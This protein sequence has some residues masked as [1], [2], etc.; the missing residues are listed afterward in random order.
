MANINEI[1]ARAA[2]LRDETALNSISPERAGGIMYDTLLAL[3]ELWLQ[4]GAA[5][6]ISKIYASVA[7][8]EA[9]TAPVSDLTGK[10]LRPGQIV[11][12]ASSDS[13]NGSVYRYNGTESPS[14]SLVGSIGNLDP[15]DSLDSDS[16]T[17]PLAA[18]QG[19]V[20]DGKISQLGQ[21]VAENIMKYA[22]VIDKMRYDNTSASFIF[23]NTAFL[24]PLIKIPSGVTSINW[25][26]NGATNVK[27][28][29]LKED[30]TILDYY[31]QNPGSS[32]TI[33]LPA[34][35]AY[36]RAAFDWDVH[37]N[38]NK[39]SVTY[40]DNVVL[41]DEDS[42]FMEVA[43]IDSG[44]NPFSNK[45]TRSIDVYDK[46]YSLTGLIPNV[47]ISE[48]QS[49]LK[50]FYEYNSTAFLTELIPLNGA[51]TIHW[52]YHDVSGLRIGFYDENKKC[53]DSW[54]QSG[55]DREITVP[56]G[57]VF[58]RGAFDWN[59]HSSLKDWKIVDNN[60]NLLWSE[61]MLTSEMYEAIKDLQSNV[62]EEDKF[63]LKLFNTPSAQAP[64]NN[65][66]LN[67]E[68][69]LNTWTSGVFKIS[70]MIPV[71]IGD[72]V[73]FTGASTGTSAPLVGFS[74][75]AYGAENFV[76]DLIPEN[77]YTAN[78]E[79]KK[80]VKITNTAIKYVASCG[81]VNNGA[82]NF[83]VEVSSGTNVIEDII[84]LSSLR[85]YYPNAM[86]K[87]Q[88]FVQKYLSGEDVNIML[89]GDSIT[90]VAN[91]KQNSNLNE[92]P[93]FM[94]HQNWCYWL[95]K[96]INKS[97]N[98]IH[99]R[100]D[101]PDFFTFTGTFAETSANSLEPYNYVSTDENP[102]FEFDWNLADYEKTNVLL[103]RNGGQCSGGIKIEILSNGV[104]T[105]DLVEYFNGS[106]WVEANGVVLSLRLASDTSPS[107]LNISRNLRNKFR[108]KA[109]SGTIS[110]KVSK[111]STEG[112]LQ[113]WG[114][115]QW[116][117]QGVFI[118]NAAFG[119]AATYE[120][121]QGIS[122]K[123]THHLPDL[124]LFE[125][126][127]VNNFGDRMSESNSKELMYN[128]FYDF[129]WGD[130][131]GTTPNGLSLKELSN[132]WTD[133]QVILIVPHWRHQWVDGNEFRMTIENT[134]VKYSALDCYNVVLGLIKAK[135]DLEYL[136]LGAEMKREAFQRG[137][138]L[139]QS[140]NGITDATMDATDCFTQ[141]TVHLNN[142]GSK[143]YGKYIAPIFDM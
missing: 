143:I 15:V 52:Y 14:W 129:I 94:E 65:Y 96:Y 13:D 142:L 102:S 54:G 126:T 48:N 74:K 89:L 11:V 119:G 98:I 110:V 47:K 68:G 141:D 111:N 19:K 92:V 86:S 101:Y 55:S 32:R 139:E 135:G 132:N 85:N 8:M 17:L 127:L 49:T 33:N 133:W 125:L 131:S 87:A 80:S 21:Q 69:V 39:W 93:C 29:C 67:H 117:G 53:F 97:Q 23:D 9:D 99:R 122:E 107:G 66:R 24:T 36:V 44:I 115:E 4:Q 81:Y 1:L 75:D 50:P 25:N 61:E 60:N 76:A 82:F 20:L 59:K 63:Q 78:V 26:Y 58:V 137:L 95:W 83:N 12:I 103:P 57:A 22:G 40:G 124:V 105:D 90:A 72:I 116:N 37:S 18:H 51:T 43:N 62:A 38:S 56:S 138:T 77:S 123:I 35:T 91:Q 84:T 71:R 73:T 100:Y 31:S 130:R 3:N 10:P 114:V 7:A 2:A 6:V 120:L 106:S 79:F 5:L 88:G 112:K 34:N 30:Y 118:I 121:A 140:Y 16:T 45:V 46:V 28:L 64:T 134:P 41:W 27:L 108:R 113:M 104:A 109:A 136:N 128:D 70:R 42:L